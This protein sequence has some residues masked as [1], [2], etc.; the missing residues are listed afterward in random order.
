[1]IDIGPR[2]KAMQKELALV[3]SRMLAGTITALSL[4]TAGEA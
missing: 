1:L 4:L 2:G 3:A